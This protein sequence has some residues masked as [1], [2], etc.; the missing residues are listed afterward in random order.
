MKHAG[1]TQPS[2]TLNVVAALSAAV[3]LLAVA[4]TR[5]I[6]APTLL[7][8]IAWTL[9]AVS[10]VAGMQLARS[11]ATGE[12]RIR[13]ALLTA[14][15]VFWLVGQIGWDVFSVAGTPGSPNIA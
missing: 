11:T 12:R 13:G 6:D 3:A 15:A 8:D 2:R 4:L 1:D 10:A 9:A 5:L 14:A 7:W